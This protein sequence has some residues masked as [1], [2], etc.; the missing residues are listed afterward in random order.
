MPLKWFMVLFIFAYSGTAS[1][2]EHEKT[3]LASPIGSL[4]DSSGISK[5]VSKSSFSSTGNN[6]IMVPDGF[7]R[8]AIKKGDT[9]AKICNAD[10]SCKVIFMKVN[11]LDNRH[12]PVGKNVLVPVDVNKAM[13]YVPVPKTLADSRGEREIR[14]FLG[15]QYFG[16]YENGQLFFWGPVSSGKKDKSTPPGKFFVNYKQ[17]FK[18][19][20]K[21]ENAPMPF[22]INYHNGYF[23][24]Q[25]SLPGYPASHGCVRLLPDDAE[26]LFFWARLR[27]PVTVAKEL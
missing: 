11:R 2:S 15:L 18:F 10:S 24:H 25:Q 4:I 17:R 8:K 16:A 9:L 22:S 13:L 12:F 7:I 21:Y 26:R 6:S 3:Y 19:S 14:I 27:D 1:A 5:A 23:I 20:V